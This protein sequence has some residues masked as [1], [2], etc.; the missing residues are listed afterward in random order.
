MPWGGG[1]GTDLK[2][3]V[4]LSD[5][6]ASTLRL[7]RSS[8]A[9][10]CS[11]AGRQL[12]ITSP[13]YLRIGRGRSSPPTERT[14]HRIRW[15]AVITRA[16]NPW[17]RSRIP[18]RPRRD[19]NSG[20]RG[21]FPGFSTGCGVMLGRRGNASL[22]K[23]AGTFAVLGARRTLTA[24]PTQPP[25]RRRGLRRPRPVKSCPR[26]RSHRNRSAI[27]KSV[28]P[29]TVRQRWLGSWGK[30]QTPGATNHPVRPSL[31]PH[32]RPLGDHS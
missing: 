6:A 5:R 25:R 8:A 7:C 31:L 23:L 28:R 4:M 24:C 16:R 27:S 17:K 32:G 21:T 1:I 30:D 20:E 15:L 29:L 22:P 18:P 14:S 3:R 2:N 9:V 13:S 12:P 10:G 26:E 11:F 19:S